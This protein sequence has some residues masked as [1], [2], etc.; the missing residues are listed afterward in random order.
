MS[1][2]DRRARR[3]LSGMPRPRLCIICA[4]TRGGSV[5]AR[6]ATGP[7]RR[8]HRAA[9]RACVCHDVAGTCRARAIAA[10]SRARAVACHARRHASH[11]RTRFRLMPL[12]MSRVFISRPRALGGDS[13]APGQFARR[14]RARVRQLGDARVARG[15]AEFAAPGA[16]ANRRSASSL[17]LTRKSRTLAAAKFNQRH[18]LVDA[19]SYSSWR[20]CSA[21][22]SPARLLHLRV[23][24]PDE[25]DADAPDRPR[26]RRL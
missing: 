10:P 9:R 5:T 11:G 26:A 15:L 4:N 24:Q 18:R 3:A 21:A 25:D 8:R 16:L 20:D 7:E 22:V 19:A 23:D 6:D 17:A 13:R 2:R 14:G 12:A 1:P